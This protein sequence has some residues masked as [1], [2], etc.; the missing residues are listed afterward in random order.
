MTALIIAVI[1]ASVAAVVAIRPQISYVKA[2]AFAVFCA[3][4]ILVWQTALGQPRHTGW[5]SGLHG[6]VLA[7]QLDQ[8][9]AIR[10]WVLRDGTTRPVYFALPWRET[11]AEQLSKA[12]DVARKKRGQV[13]IDLRGKH[14]GSGKGGKGAQG[15]HA[16]GTAAK[17]HLP[18]GQSRTV[19]K[20]LPPVFYSSSVA[21]GP[22]KER[23]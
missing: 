21:G 3:V 5:H 6:V 23:P 4:S 1:A 2:I 15:Q 10:L 22:P 13:R 14:P 9:R 8:P 17:G 18:A 7:F 19:L 11:N 20:H 16:K 12:A